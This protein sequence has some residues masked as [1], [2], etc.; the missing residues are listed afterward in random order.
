MSCNASI[1]AVDIEVTLSGPEFTISERHRPRSINGTKRDVIPPVNPTAQFENS[2]Y[3]DLASFNATVDSVL[4]PFFSLLVNSR[5]AIPISALTDLTQQQKVADAII[6]QHNIIAAQTLSATA[7][8]PVFGG[9]INGAPAYEDPGIFAWTGQGS[10]NDT[11]LPATIIGN[12]LNMSGR[13]VQSKTTTRVLEALLTTA[14]VL[15]ISSWALE[16]KKGVLPRLPTCVAS[17]VAMLVDGNLLEYWHHETSQE[18][19]TT[20]TSFTRKFGK[21]KVFSLGLPNSKQNFGI[22]VTEELPLPRK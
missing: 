5:Y 16:E 2:V 21:M 22:W 11:T 17:I 4:D 6:F 20:V 9:Y 7:R 19:Q 15:G 8:I 10:I 3:Q 1:S 18:A 14:V 12:P 13:V